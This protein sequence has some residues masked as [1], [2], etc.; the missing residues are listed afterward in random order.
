[1]PLQ[2]CRKF[3][4]STC[5]AAWVELGGSKME[6]FLSKSGF[7][8]PPSSEK[9]ALERMLADE[10]ARLVDLLE[11]VEEGEKPCVDAERVKAALRKAASGELKATEIPR[12]IRRFLIEENILF[13]DPTRGTVRP[14]GRLIQKAIINLSCQT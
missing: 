8:I 11:A 12:K 14:Q 7:R 2:R 1:M 6:E 13:Y 10:L 9:E 3:Y 4:V 5:K